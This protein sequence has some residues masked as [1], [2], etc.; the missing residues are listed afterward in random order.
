ML[1]LAIVATSLALAASAKAKVPANSVT[2][3]A[4]DAEPDKLQAR[5]AKAHD[6]MVA[7]FLEGKLL[8]FQMAPCVCLLI[9]LIF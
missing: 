5:M 6:S 7:K 2:T 1:L 3:K 4:V 8:S 9:W